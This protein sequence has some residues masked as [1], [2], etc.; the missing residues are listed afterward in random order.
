MVETIVYYSLHRTSFGVL[1]SPINR[2]WEKELAEQ[3][4][5]Q[6]VSVTIGDLQLVLFV[7]DDH[8]SD[9]DVYEQI[10]FLRLAAIGLVPEFH[11]SEYSENPAGEGFVWGEPEEY[12]Q[13]EDVND[14]DDAL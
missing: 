10:N 3:E 14:E 13:D 6:T 8:I 11:V 2:R 1:S 7:C 9:P 4:A 5:K 12:Y